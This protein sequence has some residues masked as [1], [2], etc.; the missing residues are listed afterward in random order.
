MVLF[1]RAASGRRPPHR[2][3]ARARMRASGPWGLATLLVRNQ[4]HAAA[5][6]TPRLIPPPP[7]LLCRCPLVRP[8]HATPRPLFK[9]RLPRHRRQRANPTSA[10]SIGPA[11]TTATTTTQH[12]PSAAA[13]HAADCPIC[14][15]VPEP[16]ARVHGPPTAGT[17]TVIASPDAD[18]SC[19]L[20][21]TRAVRAPV[22]CR[23]HTT[24]CCA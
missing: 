15:R 13:A 16:Q 7:P 10:D 9:R 21:H 4:P 2:E 18:E 20:R 6:T 23:S 24:C 17:L 19:I 22:T 5:T 11:P 8:R 14:M 1:L 12:R 3:R